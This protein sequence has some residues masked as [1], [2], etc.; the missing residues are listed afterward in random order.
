MW[1]SLDKKVKLYV[2]FMPLSHHHNAV[3]MSLHVMKQQGQKAKA[4]ALLEMANGDRSFEKLSMNSEMHEL[5]AQKIEDNRALAEEFGVRGTP[6]AFNTKG[7]NV[8]WNSLG[9]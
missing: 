8:A 6:S 2:F 3:S 7:E 5:F 9:K 1:P 4:K